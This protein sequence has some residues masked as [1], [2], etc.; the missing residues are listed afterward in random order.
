MGVGG[1]PGTLPGTLCHT[2]KLHTHQGNLSGGW[3]ASGSPM[4]TPPTELPT[5]NQTNSMASAQAT[6]RATKH[7]NHS[8]TYSGTTLSH[9]GTD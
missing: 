9:G 6:N 3:A 8:T 2:G 5:T 1:H 7:H 4:P